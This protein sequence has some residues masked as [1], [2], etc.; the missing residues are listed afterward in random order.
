MP[1]HKLLFWASRQ[2]PQT[3]P[4]ALRHNHGCSNDGQSQANFE[5]GK[6]CEILTTGAVA[7]R[8]LCGSLRWHGSRWDAQIQLCDMAGT[9]IDKHLI[10][11]W[12]G[13][14]ERPAPLRVRASFRP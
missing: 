10:A 12:L 14:G 11:P 1:R 5:P 3:E 7:E 13:S 6:T 9:R 4:H 8:H 2:L